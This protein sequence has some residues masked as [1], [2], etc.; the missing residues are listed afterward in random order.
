MSSFPQQFGFDRLLVDPNPEPW[1]SSRRTSLEGKVEPE[2]GVERFG[3]YALER[4]ASNYC[5]I[6]FVICMYVYVYI[7]RY[8]YMFRCRPAFLNTGGVFRRPFACAA[9]F[10]I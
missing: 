9:R 3:L 6:D 5:S 8:I 2:F 1:R 7:Y 10:R 4:G